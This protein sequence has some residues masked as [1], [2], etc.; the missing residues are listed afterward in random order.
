MSNKSKYE[1]KEIEILRL[2]VDKAEKRS[3]RKAANAPQVKNII[4]EVELF[5]RQ[6]KLICYGGTAI[7]NILPQQDQFYDKSLEI[8]DYDFYSP[9]AL[10]DAKD[11]ADIYHSK[12]FPDVEAKSGVHHGTFKVYVNFIPVADITQLDKE[13]FKT[14]KKEAISVNGI[15]YAPPNFLRMAMYLEL[16]RPKGDVS[17]WEK[18]LKRLILLNKNHPI[19]NPKCNEVNFQRSMESTSNKLNREVDIYNVVKETFINQEVVFFGGFANTLYSNYMPNKLKRRLQSS[20]DFDVL[21]IDP[22][23]T[24][25]IVKE[26][27]KDEGINNIKIVKHK[28]VG[29]II[30]PHYEIKVGIDSIAFIYEPLACHSYN[31]IKLKGS[32]LKIA[33]IDT[34][35]S[36]Y[37]AFLYTNR[38]YYDPDRLLCMS[39]YLFKVQQKNRLQQKG[40]LRRFSISCYGTQS[41]LESM[42]QEK[43][44]KFE[45]LKNKK[46]SKEYEE[47]FLKYSPG[48]DSKKTSNSN[49]KKKTTSK[50][51]VSKKKQTKVTTKKNSN[52]K[53]RKKSKKVYFS[54]K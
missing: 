18:V 44:E 25:T 43:T 35:L 51:S 15:L 52:K 46:N 28:G 54:W 47:W 32:I 22:N 7:N 45:E 4:A 3:D 8:P 30:A 26:R 14:M 33:T 21:A 6:R 12:G 48:I 31:I 23:V 50:K 13:L 10:K 42:R 40:L 27:L 24:S 17:R 34:M 16:S 19:K 39:Q 49:T 2:A 36:F 5:L 53:K 9:N 1:E 29:E 38:P 41:T 20:P 37:L 11:L